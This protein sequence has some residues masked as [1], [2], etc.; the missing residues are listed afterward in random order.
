MTEKVARE[1]KVGDFFRPTSMGESLGFALVREVN[2]FTDVDFCYMIVQAPDGDIM[3]FDLPGDTPVEVQ[4]PAPEER[5]YNDGPGAPLTRELAERAWESARAGITEPEEK[6]MRQCQWCTAITG[7][8]PCGRC[9]EWPKDY[10][11]GEITIGKMGQI[12]KIVYNGSGEEESTRWYRVVM[13]ILDL[14]KAQE[15]AG[16]NVLEKLPP[17]GG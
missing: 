2:L 11:P 13:A 5:E 15:I 7:N 4:E 10:D 14:T 17:P 3:P 16:A 9:S 12:A 8:D 6:P 1:I